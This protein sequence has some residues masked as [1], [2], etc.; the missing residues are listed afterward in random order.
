MSFPSGSHCIKK[1]NGV[2]HVHTS[3]D[4]SRAEQLDVVNISID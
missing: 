4:T 2:K 3:E 1:G